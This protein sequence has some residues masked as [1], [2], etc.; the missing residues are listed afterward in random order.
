MK[1]HSGQFFSSIA[2]VALLAGA[3]FLASGAAAEE[4]VPADRVVVHKAERKLY[5]Y[6]GSQLIGSYKVALGLNPQG[7]KQREKDYRTPEG[8]YFLSRRNTRSDFFLAIQVSYPNKQDERYAHR[9]GWAPGGAIMIHGLPNVPKH[10]P[11]YYA[12]TDWTDGCIA[13][14]NSDMVEV[15]MRTQDNTPI[16]IFP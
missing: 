13:L 14:S 3:L 15:W 8:R 11:L 4:L 9:H 10:T 5:L 1:L 12:E 2:M 16:D 6:H 7:P